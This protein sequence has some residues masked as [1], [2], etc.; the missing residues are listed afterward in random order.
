LLDPQGIYEVDEDAVARTLAEQGGVPAPDA[1]RAG[2]VLLHSL[3][4]F[5][6]AGATGE[7][8]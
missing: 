1:G 6:D 7:I 2:P 4:G 8:A 5:I 3:R